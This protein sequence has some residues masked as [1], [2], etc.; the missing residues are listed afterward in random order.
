MDFNVHIK[1]PE[2]GSH[3]YTHISSLLFIYNKLITGLTYIYK[4]VTSYTDNSVMD[5]SMSYVGKLG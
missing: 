2:K 5:K 1:G 3:C 4:Q